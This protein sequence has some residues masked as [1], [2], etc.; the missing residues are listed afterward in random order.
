[1]L[2]GT[3]CADHS[4]DQDRLRAVFCDG[5]IEYQIVQRYAE[6]AS[7]HVL[8]VVGNGL[9]AAER[10]RRAAGAPDAEYGLEVELRVKGGQVPLMGHGGPLPVGMLKKSREVFPRYPVGPREEFGRLWSL[11]DR[12]LWN[13]AGEDWGEQI[14][15]VDFDRMLGG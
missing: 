15:S 8:C 7:S 6:V 4:D 14:L 5:L 10:F 3:V 13:M 11:F 2:R 12:D 9:L 1:M